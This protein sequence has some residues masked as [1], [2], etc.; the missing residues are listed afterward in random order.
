ME[1]HISAVSAVRTARALVRAVSRQHRIEAGGDNKP[2]TY[3]RQHKHL[4]DQRY[5]YGF[6]VLGNAF[7]ILQRKR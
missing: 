5:G 4:A 1:S 6:G 3:C 7:K 2:E